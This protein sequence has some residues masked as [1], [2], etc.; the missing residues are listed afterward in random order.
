M[1]TN[2]TVNTNIENEGNLVQKRFVFVLETSKHMIDK[3]NKGF[4]SWQVFM[5]SGYKIEIIWKPVY[6]SEIYI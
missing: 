1:L 5:K 2:I 6:K 3:K 4:H